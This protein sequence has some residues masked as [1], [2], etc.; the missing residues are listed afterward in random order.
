MKSTIL[1]VQ[2]ENFP[3]KK[4]RS[5][6]SETLKP[7]PLP[8]TQ[9]ATAP[10]KSI[11]KNT[12]VV[13]SSS[14]P[15]TKSTSELSPSPLSSGTY[16]MSPMETL[17]E[18]SVGLDANGVS[19][20][21]LIEAYNVL[22]TR[23][24]SQIRVILGKQAPQSA[25]ASLREHSGP[26]AEALRRDL[27]RAREDPSTYVQRMSHADSFQTT[28]EIDEDDLRVSRDLALLSQQVL[29]LISDLFSF[30]PLFSLFST[31]DLRS[32][33]NEL[34]VLGM[35][36]SIPSP[37][38]RRTWTLIVWTLSV[39]NLPSEVLSPSKD[40]IVS[41]LKRAV[42]GQ[43][44]K[45]QAQ[46]DALKA[47][48]HLLKYHP[49]LFLTPLLDIFPRILHD[50]MADSSALRLQAAY[51]LGRLALAKISTLS[52]KTSCHDTMST[53][54]SGFLTSETT[55]RKSGQ[56]QLLL[57]DFINT[58]LCSDNPSHPADGPFWAIQLLASSVILVDCSIFSHPRLLKLAMQS[59]E[60]IAAH[61][62]GPVRALHPYVWKCLI[63]AFSRL[64]VESDGDD[65]RNSAFLT[66]MQD[67]RGDIG[68]ALAVCL[69]DRTTSDEGHDTSASV[70]R[71]LVLVEHLLKGKSQ[72]MQ[73]DGIALLTQL[74]YAPNPSVLGKEPQNTTCILVP[75]LFDGSLVHAKKVAS[76]VNSIGQLNIKQVPHLSDAEILFHWDKL[77]DLWTRATNISLRKDFSEFRLGPP[78]LSADQYRQD[79]LH[80]WQSL[81]LM[82]SNLTQGCAH[83][84]TSDP[85]AER[86]STL[87][88]SFLVPVETVDAQV[89]QLVLVGKMWHIMANVFQHTWLS[90]PAEFL[91]AAVLKQTYCLADD[92][93]RDAW[94]HLCSEL[95]TIGLPGLVTIVKDQSEAQMPSEMRRQLWMLTVRS[96]QK[97]DDP[98]AWRDLVYLVSVPFR[99]WEMTVSE[100][101]AWEWLLYKVVSIAGSVDV[102]P[103]AVVESIFESFDDGQ[104]DA[105]SDSPKEFLTLLSHVALT[106]RDTL[107][108]R[109]ITTTDKVLHDLYPP[110]ERLLPISLRLMR[111]LQEIIISTPSA[112]VLSFV[113]ALQN[114]M[115]RWLEDESNALVDDV[116]E[117]VVR[118]L[119]STPLSAI[120]HHEPS[121][122]NLVA[123]SRLLATVG[124][125]NA[126]D[127]F[128]RATYHGRQEFYEF[129]PENMK[130]SLRAIGDVFGG[131]LAADLSLDV[132]SEAENSG[133]PYSQE[134]RAGPSSSFDYYA[135]ASRY[136]FDADTAMC[137]ETERQEN[138]ASTVRGSSLPPSSPFELPV[139]PQPFTTAALDQLKEYSSRIDDSMANESL[140]DDKGSHAS[141]TIPGA[142][143]PSR[144]SSHH[145]T[146]STSR[147]PRTSSSGSKRRAEPS[148]VDVPSPKRRKTSQERSS[149]SN[150]VASSSRRPGEYISGPMGRVHSI[151]LSSTHR[152]SRSDPSIKHEAKGKFVPMGRAHSKVLSSTHRSSRSVP[153]AKH[154][155]KGKFVPTYADVRRRQQERSLPTPSP[156][157][158]I[159]TSEVRHL[160]RTFG[161]ETVPTSEDDEMDVEGPRGDM[162]G[163]PS[164]VRERHAAPLRREKTSARLDALERAYAAVADEDASQIPAED[165]IGNAL[166]EQMS[167]TLG[168]R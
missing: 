163:R 20:H 85:F 21:D 166:N 34:L 57:R 165:L 141:A 119:Y 37:S 98:A 6:T 64:P 55:K 14:M 43:I 82:S 33:L 122:E 61:K 107:P 46:L 70:A 36:P 145:T 125:A 18:S 1:V 90:S 54:I 115:C 32:V 63:W 147:R 129:Y 41:V 22:S 117:E 108:H 45:Y 148:A 23:I 136:P 124:D 168:G 66:L 27:K 29:R 133:V 102:E 77:V 140:K 2:K 92:K 120:R 127:S 7:P 114:G 131:S 121:A 75:Q 84:T 137:D 25:L 48:N 162:F 99:A 72:A 52:T 31:N 130:T 110:Q 103:T 89:Q 59:L 24:R 5:W 135:D 111:R 105:F 12:S 68:L 142:T 62:Q 97:S 11:L 47:T 87:I 155:A 93:V 50:L 56:D 86:V 126:F 101:E 17:L 83:L 158:T 73:L 19:L 16:F 159:S 144:S 26:I 94:A 132:D 10:L 13:L 81:L 76:V 161:C 95:I 4:S 79:L 71:A 58:A 138:N 8:R 167:K 42:E 149:A 49:A 35:A 65:T 143:G 74:L 80:G 15:P 106:G 9:L 100:V 112:L 67:L 51:A 38:S 123:L 28:I 88:A 44:G 39:Q 160:Q 91:L 139:L 113:L 164:P 30:P 3:T 60:K 134:S 153:S 40:D 150:A 152:S 109:I 78:Y 53:I 154:K 116:R 146:A 156:S 128:W 69:V 104:M 157:R 151:V 118:C 96:I